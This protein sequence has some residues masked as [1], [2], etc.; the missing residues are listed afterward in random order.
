VD[1]FGLIL[2]TIFVVTGLYCQ[3]PEDAIKKTA[4][5]IKDI[6]LP[7]QNL[8]GAL[9]D[10]RFICL[11]EMH[12]TKEPAEFIICLTRTFIANKQ[13]VVIGL[14]IPEALMEQFR[15]QQDSIGLTKTEF[16]SGKTSDGRA[17]EAWFRA[18]NECNKLGVNFCFFDNSD[19][20]RDF[21]MYE[22]LIKCYQ[23]D[24]TA[25]I[26]TLTG[27]VHNRIVPFNGSKTMGCHLIDRFDNKICS[28]NHIYNR[29]TMFNRTSEG[30]DV[31]TVE[32]TN[33]IFSTSTNFDNYYIANIFNI[34]EY[35]GFFFTKTM[36]ASLPWTK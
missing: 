20:D 17:S 25:I 16:F 34:T 32:P 10:Y 15:K 5:E 22:K 31:H 27:N 23:S 13:R 29:G 2:L 33:G 35:S 14:E 11:G 26:L 36:S 19:Y 28:I 7:N 18:I 6:T 21:G 12:G 3:N 30:L 4:I 8:Y 1:R 9:K 24:N